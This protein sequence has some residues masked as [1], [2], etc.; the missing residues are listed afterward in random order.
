MLKV[1]ELRKFNFQP[2]KDFTIE[3]II[4][5]PEISMTWNWSSILCPHCNNKIDNIQEHK[6]F[7]IE[8]LTDT[9]KKESEI[10]FNNIMVIGFTNDQK[11]LLL[12]PDKKKEALIKS[13][14]FSNLLK[15]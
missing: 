6:F 5:N 2:G 9:T 4:E 11:V 1:G 8:V 3:E 14:K 12:T 15:E 10:N 7:R 13:K